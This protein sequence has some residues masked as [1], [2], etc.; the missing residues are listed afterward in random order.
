MCLNNGRDVY[1]INNLSL[2]LTSVSHFGNS[3]NRFNVCRIEEK[4]TEKCLEAVMKK[5]P[6]VMSVTLG[7]DIDSQVLPLIGRYCHR[8]K[9]LTFNDKCSLIEHQFFREYGHKLE[10]IYLYHRNNEV[11]HYLENCTNLKFVYNIENSIL[12]NE[13]KEFLPKLERISYNLI[14]YPE[15]IT[16]MKIITDKYSQTMKTLN[17]VLYCRTTEELKLCIDSISQFKNLIK[18]KLEIHLAKT[19]PIDNCLSLIGQRCSKLVKL[20]LSISTVFNVS[21]NFFAIFTDFKAIKKLKIDLSYN[22][23]LNGSVEC[24]KHCQQLY[25]LDINY[26]ELTEDF[27]ANIE[28]FVP[29]LQSLKIKS[30]EGFSESF[31]N[32]FRSMKNMQRVEHIIDDWT[33]Q[34]KNW[35]FG[36]QLIDWLISDGINVKPSTHSCGILIRNVLETIPVSET[37]NIFLTN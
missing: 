6:N 1:L 9:S 8:I 7:V 12:F 30:E 27:F 11:E 33:G 37:C 17:V 32:S 21:E 13:N 22:R 29:K 28:T 23:V 31:V 25:E 14:I 5:C 18:L 20:D 34:S 26:M 10:E 16:K 36:K 35:Y 2:N 19:E 4:S 3:Y 24:F 15:M